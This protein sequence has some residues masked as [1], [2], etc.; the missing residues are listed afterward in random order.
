MLAKGEIIG[1]S[2]EMTITSFVHYAIIFLGRLKNRTKYLN[3]YSWSF[4][5][6]TSEAQSRSVTTQ[7]HNLIGGKEEEEEQEEKQTKYNTS[8]NMN[9]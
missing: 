4:E 5:R 3:Q 6:G 1:V 7:P 8:S 2:E 9:K